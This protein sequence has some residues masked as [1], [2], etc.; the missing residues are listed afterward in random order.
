[1]PPRLR[2]VSP[3]DPAPEP[4]PPPKPLSLAQAIETG[5]VLE[6]MLAQRRQIASDI[7]AANGPAVAALH[8]QLTLLTQEIAEEQAVR[9]K[10]EGEADAAAIPDEDFDASAV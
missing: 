1:M 3:A 5:D 6:I 9:R 10:A 7:P 2:S 4:T 8:R